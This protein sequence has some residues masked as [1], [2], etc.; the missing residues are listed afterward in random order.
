M[1]GR[2]QPKRIGSKLRAVRDKLGLSQTQMMRLLG[3]KCCYTRISEFE[4]GKRQPNLLTLLAY[5]RAAKIPLE[6][7]VD[8]E[9]ELELTGRDRI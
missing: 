7:I 9:L 5:A 2:S 3:I 4:R 1:S 8:D 6:Q